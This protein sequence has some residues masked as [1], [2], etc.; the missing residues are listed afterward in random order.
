MLDPGTDSVVFNAGLAAAAPEWISLVLGL[1][2]GLALFLFGLDQ[3][4]V[5]LKAVAGDRMRNLLRRLTVNRLASVATGAFVTAVIQSSSVT[6]VLLV[7]FI[8]S[9]LMSLSQAV[10]VILG[11]NIG[12]TITAQIVAFKVAKLAMFMIAAGFG[13]G[14]LA[15]RES[16]RHHGNGM[17]GLG[18]VFLGMTLMGEAMAPLR[19]YAPFLEWMLRM[20]NPAFGVLV[21][22]G[23]TALVQSSSATTAVVIAMASQGL[24]SLPAG[25]VLVLGAN[26]GTCVTALLAS[27]GKPREAIR[28]ALVH[29]LFNVLGVVLWVGFIDQLAG[30]VTL[31]SPQSEGLAGVA[32]LA[33]DTPRQIANAHTLF[34]VANSLIFLPF[35]GLLVGLCERLV[36]DR[37]LPEEEL[38]RA[39]YLDDAL[40]DTPS[41]ALEHARREIVRIGEFTASMLEA[42]LPAML[43]GDEQAL[44]DVEE[45]D[46]TIDVL[47][48]HVV[49]YLGRLSQKG[50]TDAQTAELLLLLAIANSFESAADVIETDLVRSGRLRADSEVRISPSTAKLIGE[51]HV[52]VSRA[53]RG[54]LA[55]VEAWDS[56]LAGEV[57]AQKPTIHALANRVAVHQVERLVAPE[58]N[59]VPA[60][61]IESDMIE[62]L[63]RVFYFAKRMAHDVAAA[64]AQHE[65][66]AL[67]RSEEGA[68]GEGSP[69]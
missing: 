56:E 66:T 25:I 61:A 33:A 30:W 68:G 7:S 14:F 52:E 54:A 4:T 15:R 62:D 21:A 26:V 55:A 60:F 36:P 35:A 65:G 48:R 69:A 47:H 64:G 6:T 28:A 9:G 8:S 51:F 16:L 27:I 31:L 12:T 18:L 19:A 50:L 3:M 58:A 45:R 41:L 5:A 22:A 53:L 57:I 24:I 34:N 20:E 46:Q 17:L 37:P 49:A 44:R 42:I 40:L 32:R 23:F 39:R 13:V 43:E 2:G 67:G 63:R 10:G 11:A 29:V 38:I 1:L 59:R